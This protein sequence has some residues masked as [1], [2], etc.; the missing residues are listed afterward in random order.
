ML[1]RNQIK[2]WMLLC[3]EIVNSIND[4]LIIERINNEPLLQQ[5]SV[6]LDISLKT[7]VTGMNKGFKEHPWASI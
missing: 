4:G 1:V 2:R 3:C 6:N 7:D 5:F